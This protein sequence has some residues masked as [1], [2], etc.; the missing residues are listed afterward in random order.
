MYGS[1][2]D[3]LTSM[4]STLFA[5]GVI[6]IIFTAIGAFFSWCFFYLTIKAAV[7]NGMI[8]A[9]RKT[10]GLGGGTYIQGYPPPQDLGA[11][12]APTY[13]G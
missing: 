7:R 8:E 2:T 5:G 13:R 9:S 3:P 12:A 11:P 1:G 6:A 10:G 4:L